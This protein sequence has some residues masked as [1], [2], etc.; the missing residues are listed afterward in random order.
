M[1]E[2]RKVYAVSRGSYSDYRIV[3]VFSTKEQADELCRRYGE[4]MHDDADVEEWI[5]DA[6][7]PNDGLLQYTVWI[8]VDRNVHS[9]DVRDADKIVDDRNNEIS[10][11]KARGKRV[12]NRANIYITCLAKSKEHAVKIANEKLTEVLAAGW[13]GK[14]DHR[15]GIS[16]TEW[17]ESRRTLA[18]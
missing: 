14:E 15:D 2:P 4:D 16:F 18:T 5:V 10:L 3:A 6:P 11:Y 9:L 17:L 12:E 7:M 1:S 13:T 8:G